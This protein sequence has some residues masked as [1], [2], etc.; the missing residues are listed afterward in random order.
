MK[1]TIHVPGDMEG[2]ANIVLKELKAGLA[3]QMFDI[4]SMTGDQIIDRDNLVTRMNEA[5]T[6]MRADKPGCS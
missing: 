6:N 3:N 1:H 4:F 2:L 5:I